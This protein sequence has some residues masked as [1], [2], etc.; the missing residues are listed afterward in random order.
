MVD[1]RD[2][3]ERD[4]GKSSVID[5]GEIRSRI[6]AEDPGTYSGFL[7]CVRRFDPVISMIYPDPL[8]RIRFCSVMMGDLV[9]NHMVDEELCIEEPDL[10]ARTVESFIIDQLEEVGR[11][12]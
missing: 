3:V 12:F 6:S 11:S 5:V 10:V 2:F 4:N 9:S 7:D 8:D 1:S